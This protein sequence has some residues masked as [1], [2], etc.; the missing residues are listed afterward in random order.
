MTIIEYISFSYRQG[1]SDPSLGGA[2]DRAVAPLGLVIYAISQRSEGRLD[3][4]FIKKFNPDRTLT[5]N[6]IS[7]IIII[8]TNMTTERL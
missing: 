7:K 3:A 5:N 1:R 8:T 4:M 2:N 6:K